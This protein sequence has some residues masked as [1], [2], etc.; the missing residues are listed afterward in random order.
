[1]YI[2]YYIASVTT[3][4]I[5]WG[6]IATNQVNALYPWIHNQFNKNDHIIKANPFTTSHIIESWSFTTIYNMV[7]KATIK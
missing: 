1:M 3:K 5:K 6:I 2:K 7:K 4:K